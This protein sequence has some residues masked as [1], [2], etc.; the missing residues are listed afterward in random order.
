MRTDDVT[1]T[2]AQSP[3]NQVSVTHNLPQSICCQIQQDV[4]H[5]FVPELRSLHKVTGITN[6]NV[7]RTNL[8]T[9]T[10]TLPEL[11]AVHNRTIFSLKPTSTALSPHAL[12]YIYPAILTLRERVICV[13]AQMREIRE[14]LAREEREE[15]EVKRVTV[16]SRCS[17]FVHSMVTAI[18]NM[19]PT[20]PIQ[21]FDHHQH[22]A[23]DHRHPVPSDPCSTNPPS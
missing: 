6:G 20:S 21:C 15:V 7:Q 3:R 4:A 22:D 11:D 8:D 19:M 2:V 1:A 16:M 12:F 17:R 10:K 18:P 9:T 13:R 23:R 14:A 5:V